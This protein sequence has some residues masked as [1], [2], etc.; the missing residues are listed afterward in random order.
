MVNGTFSL[1]SL[2]INTEQSFTVSWFKNSETTSPSW[3]WEERPRWAGCMW[4]QRAL[5]WPPSTLSC[6]CFRAEQGKLISSVHIADHTLHTQFVINWSGS[7]DPHCWD[8]AW[9]ERHD[10]MSLP[11]HYLCY[12][13]LA[14]PRMAGIGLKKSIQVRAIFLPYPRIDRPCMAMPAKSL[15]CMNVDFVRPRTEQRFE[16]LRLSRVSGLHLSHQM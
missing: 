4:N 1:V 10:W 16:Q 7:M 9:H 11:F 14:A 13:G 2:H 12:Q 5:F 6:W 15:T 3:L 8:K